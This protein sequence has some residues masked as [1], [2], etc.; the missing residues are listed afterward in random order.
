M[1]DKISKSK[2]VRVGHNHRPSRVALR[3]HGVRRFRRK[4]QKKLSIS[5]L[6]LVVT[7]SVLMVSAFVN[8]VSN[9]AAPSTVSVGAVANYQTG[10]VNMDT[11]SHKF[12]INGKVGYCADSQKPHP[13]AG[14]TFSNP[15]PGGNG[16]D[17]I[18]YMGFGGDGYNDTDGIWLGGMGKRYTGEW[19][20]AITQLAVWYVLGQN[21]ANIND[22]GELT[23][24]AHEFANWATTP[25]AQNT[26]NGIFK[27]TSYIYSPTAGNGTQRVCYQAIPAPKTYWLKVAKTDA[28]TGQ[29]VKQSGYQFQISGNGM[30]PV[31]AITNATG[32]TPEVQ[33]PGPGIYTV[34]ETK[35]PAGSDYLL[36]SKSVTVQVTDANIGS[37]AAATV[38]FPN[39]PRPKLGGIKIYKEF[40]TDVDGNRYSL[41]GAVY[42]IYTNRSCTNRIDTLTTNSSGYAATGPE[43]LE[44]GTYYVK[45]ITPSPGCELDTT[46]YTV[47]VP[48]GSYDIVNSEEPIITGRIQVQKQDASGRDLNLSGFVFTATSSDG[49]RR[50]ATTNSSGVATFNNLPLGNWT[51]RET[52]AQPP[53]LLSSGWSRTFN[54]TE[55]N[56]YRTFTAE[57][58][59]TPATGRVTLRKTDSSTGDAIEGIEFELHVGSSTISTGNGTATFGGKQCTANAL[60]GTYE[61]NSSGQIAVSGLPLGTGRTTSYY[62]KE[63]TPKKPYTL[64]NGGRYDFSLT[65]NQNTAVVSVNVNATNTPATGKAELV[66]VDAD[67]GRKLSGAVFK[68][69]AQEN[70]FVN[71]EKIYSN[72]DVITGNDRLTT[73]SEGKA[74]TTSL[75]IDDDGES[76]Y[77]FVEV[78]EP[79]GYQLDT[80]PHPFTIRYVDENTPNVATVSIGEIEDLPVYGGIELH[81]VDLDLATVNGDDVD[82]QVQGNVTSFDGIRFEIV[83][84]GTYSISVDGIEYQPGEKLGEIE[85]EDG[86]KGHLIIKDGVAKTAI[87]ALPYGDYALTEVADTI[88]EGYQ[89]NTTTWHVKIRNLEQYHFPTGD[90][91]ENKVSNDVDLGQ[92]K[93]PKIDHDYA[94]DAEL[95][96]ADGINNPQG[97]A[98][99]VGAEFSIENASTHSV[100][101]GGKEYQNGDLITTIPLPDG[102][103]GNVITSGNDGIA[104]TAERVLPYGTYIVRETKAPEGY[105]LNS[106][107]S[108]TVTI[109]EHGQSIQAS[110]EDRIDDEVISSGG[111]MPKVD[112]ELTKL[113]GEETNEGNPQGN[114]TF[115]GA[116]FT[117]RNKSKASVVVG[118]QLYAPDQDI[119]TIETGEDGIA[120]TAADALPYGTYELRETKAPEGYLITDETWTFSVREDGVIVRPDKETQVDE[121]IDNQVIRGGVAMPKIDTELSQFAGEEQKEG[122]PQGDATVEGAEFEIKNVSSNHVLVDGVL[123]EPGAVVKTI[124]TDANGVASTSADTLPYG[125]YEIYEVEAPNGY[126]LSS[127]THDGDGRGEVWSFDITENGK[128]VRPAEDDVESKIDNQVIRGGVQMPKVDTEFSTLV[129]G[130]DTEENFLVDENHPQG[131]ATVDGAE[132]SITNASAHHVIVGGKLYAPGERITT[133][134]DGNRGGNLYDVIVTVNGIA[135]TTVDALPYGTYELREV[136]APTGY[137]DSAFNHDDDDSGEVWTFTVHQEGVL[138]RPDDES[139]AADVTEGIDNKIDNRIIRGGVEMPKVDTELSEYNKDGSDQR[140]EENNPQGDATVKGATFSITNVSAHEVYVGGQVYDGKGSDEHPDGERI[141]TIPIDDEGNVSD[142]I[143]TGDDGIARTTNDALPYGTYE[144]RE[145]DPPTGYHHSSWNHKDD[146]DGE[147]WTV[148]IREEGVL[149]RPDKVNDVE[150]KIDN[151]VIRGGV[152]MPKVDSEFSTLVNGKDTEENFLTDENHPQGDATVDG[153][154]FSITNVSAHHVIVGGKLYESGQRITT[155]PDGNRG[156]DLYDTIVTVDGIARTTNDALPYGTYEL[157]EVKAPTGYN[158]SSFNHDDDESGEV[159]TF[160]VREEG[161]LSRPNDKSHSETVEEG[162]DNK[163]DNQVIRGG[164]EMPKIDTELST[165][166]GQEDE[167]NPQGDAT[168]EGATFSL[169]NASKK[170]VYVG[171]QVYAPGERITTIPDG[172]NG[173]AI[174][175]VITTDKDGVA[176]TTNDALPYGT[177][178][179]R[180]VDEPTG[181]NHSSFN[182]KDAEG[183]E[184]WTF[185]IR[186]EDEMVRP[187]D[188]RHSES[189]EDGVENKID[190]RVI[191]GGVRLPKFDAVLVKQP[192]YEEKENQPTGDATLDGAEFAI[193]NV[194][195]SHVIVGGKLYESGERIETIPDA[196]NDGK[197]SNVIVTVD[198]VAQTTSDALPYG[199]YEIYEVKAPDGYEL[200]ND[201]FT[202][203]I[204][205]E[206]E[207]VKPTDGDTTAKIKDISTSTDIG[208]EKTDVELNEYSDGHAEQP[209][210]DDSDDE[211][212]DDSKNESTDANDGENSGVQVLADDATDDTSDGGIDGI[213]EATDGVTIVDPVPVYDAVGIDSNPLTNAQGDATL[214]GATFYLVNRSDNLVVVGGKVYQP[215]ERILTI[216]QPDNSYADVVTSDDSGHI[217]FG[218]EGLPYG[219][220]ELG[221]QTAPQGYNL[222]EDTWIVEVHGEKNADAVPSDYEEQKATS[223]SEPVTPKTVDDSI[224]DDVIRGGL[225]VQK[226]DKETGRGDTIVTGVKG[227][228][229]D[230]VSD[231]ENGT[232]DVVDAD[233]DAADGEE[234]E[235]SARSGESDASTDTDDEDGLVLGD[236]VES[237][238][239][240]GSG[241]TDAAEDTSKFHNA[242]LAGTMFEIRNASDKAVIVDGKL[243]QVGQV[244]KTITTDENGYAATDPDSLP[245]GTYDVYEVG[246]PHGYISSADSYGNSDGVDDDAEKTYVQTVEIREEGVIVPCARPFANQIKRGDIT[247]TKIDDDGNVMPHV[248][249]RVTSKTTGESH[250]IVTDENGV[251]DSSSS[252]I[253]HSHN[254]NANDGVFDADGNVDD[255]ALVHDAGTWFYGNA[256]GKAFYDDEAQTLPN[257]A[258]RFDPVESADVNSGDDTSDDDATSGDENAPDADDGSDDTQQDETDGDSEQDDQS[259]DVEVMANDDEMTDGDGSLVLG[260]DVDGGSGSAGSSSEPVHVNPVYE[261]TGEDGTSQQVTIGYVETDS[262][263]SFTKNSV[264]FNVDGS[265]TIV[266]DKTIVDMN[267]GERR[268]YTSYETYADG[269]WKVIVTGS[270]MLDGV[271]ADGVADADGN[272]EFDIVDN[273]D[274]YTTTTQYP[275]HSVDDSLGAFPYDQYIFEELPSEATYGH[276]LVAFEATVQRHNYLLNLG[277]ITDNV[278]DI[279]T[280]ATDQSDGDHIFTTDGT[281]T[282]VDTVEYTNLNTDREYVMTGT[283]MDYETGEP[284]KDANGNTITSSVTFQPDSTNGSVDVVFEIDASQLGGVQT[285]VF[286]D[287]Y[288]NNIHIASH[289]DIEDSG[290]RVEFRPEIGTTATADS[291]ND[292]FAYADGSVIITDTVH[293][294]GIVPGREFIV[295]GILMD[296]NTGDALI[297][298]NGETIENSVVFTPENSEGDVQV[299]FEFDASDLAGLDVVVFEDLYRIDAVTNRQPDENGEGED[300][301]STQR[302][303]ASHKD[304][305]DEGQTVNIRASDLASDQVASDLVQTGAMIG[306]GII[307]AAVMGG[308][309]YEVRKNRKGK[310]ARR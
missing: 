296:K 234:Q 294:K 284:M 254:T 127:D 305:N 286:E 54:I 108:W 292:H 195:K 9:A 187:D 69:V 236:D 33:V 303:V 114:A 133:I 273:P 45:E 169:T 146:A 118:G 41:A 100:V 121:K 225:S 147:I 178:E 103:T 232:D 180:E 199:T 214:E 1:F 113:N 278:I 7:F 56:A 198:G 11:Y 258:D 307:V 200:S 32:W 61:T 135:K 92:I 241:D 142:V 179:L 293:Y 213:T 189:E 119:M 65:W 239:S 141:M 260:D 143:T 215:G 295:H 206:G 171:G 261:V 230:A 68:V 291:T 227:E 289:A 266:Y 106:T 268:S 184:V 3:R 210:V 166:D 152:E 107:D 59:N 22:R 253:A 25:E 88:P 151:Q 23:D 301:P 29:V 44:E 267:T 197:T 43:E 8:I 167:S 249:F 176:R 203:T 201:R 5:F 37:A 134:P 47:T 28:E 110:G 162:I 256:D 216:P 288:W 150:S 156:D 221:E 91:I 248:A 168:L 145:V 250:I 102:G 233:G 276:N 155:I 125:S 136:K 39:Q 252:V 283:L 4:Q 240:N 274:A 93:M 16:L 60:L 99:M 10:N 217:A 149:V 279:H 242:S 212:S 300:V 306:F 77:A 181:Y 251:Y 49:N 211:S 95:G 222:S 55:D 46:V 97:D 115:K 272:G 138:S 13:N 262:Y 139:H 58:E 76:S 40:E 259:S 148:E 72:G 188:E 79:I 131:D 154:E 63:K 255:D 81:K 52:T 193:D 31:G 164:V 235:A 308:T 126:H 73:N 50:T 101:V 120:S 277:P 157:R 237:G 129:N 90:E 191:R 140:A 71:G 112:T 270:D 132:F 83:N 299:R 309:V 263:G 111:A 74:T 158:D 228:S 280:T 2:I 265:I 229:D 48:G 219:T 190:N 122:N 271:N 209:V 243:Y 175:D 165:Y 15:T 163:I 20:R 218:E 36:N 96:Q 30:Q 173:G 85:L 66:K 19:A 172:N 62:F 282:I 70:I 53:Y 245:Y 297:D 116:Q 275:M 287:L 302:L 57:C 21:D 223:S 298:S 204:R 87:D 192:G 170:E 174:S 75:P 208:A 98:S 104:A 183:G 144:L 285:V 226:V 78:Q 24:A 207:I 244:V 160:T 94:T 177:Y 220:Y 124:T 64:N 194:S 185:D 89:P 269:S 117:I 257:N 105:L 246:A 14:D 34:Q 161:V 27:G 137:H 84:E 153:A 310:M 231:G 186:V 42:G 281:V 38:S 196:N 202:F 12:E 205:K 80:T 247:F 264:V 51:V 17:Y 304:I 6:S 130:E 67:T 86:T 82:G 109:T 35:V 159:W 128:V 18:L 224:E 26:A 238:S 290:Q 182:H 123:Y